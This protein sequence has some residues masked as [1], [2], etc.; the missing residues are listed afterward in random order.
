MQANTGTCPKICDIKRRTRTRCRGPAGTARYLD[1]PISAPDNEQEQE[2][3]KEA[4]PHGIP[5]ARAIPSGGGTNHIRTGPSTTGAYAPNCPRYVRWM[6][7]IASIAR[8]ILGIAPGKRDRRVS[9]I[10]VSI[11]KSDEHLS[12]LRP[13]QALRQASGRPRAVR[14]VKAVLPI[15]ASISAYRRQISQYCCAPSPSWLVA[16]P[17]TTPGWSTQ[18]DS[19]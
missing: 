1:R 12:S 15:M 6:R 19:A 2:G 5:E 17:S 4:Q 7:R 16:T 13:D 14:A 8:E 18:A 11:L 10:L 9:A 3:R